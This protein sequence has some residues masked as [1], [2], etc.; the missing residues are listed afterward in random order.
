LVSN[1]N[2]GESTKPAETRPVAALPTAPPLSS[3]RAETRTEA[4]LQPTAAPVVPT[5]APVVEAR[6]TPETRRAGTSVSK[7]EDRV[8]PTR[9][10]APTPA[11]KI[12]QINPPVNPNP[13][14]PKM[15]FCAE[16]GRTGYF[17]GVPKEV[18][19][20]FKD[21]AG[22]PARDDAAR[23]KINVAVRPEE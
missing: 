15:H 18:P 9:A 3:P 4:T 23:I 19:P 5:A 7:R 12:A 16:V 17:Q 1:R 6:P 20:G 13:N 14:R 2:R 11:T 22:L 10:P 21:V 8:R